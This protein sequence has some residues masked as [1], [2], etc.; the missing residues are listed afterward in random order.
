VH[1]NKFLFNKT[2]R[3]TN[4]PNFFFSRNCI[5]FGQ[6]LCPSSVVLH[7]TFGTGVCHASLMRASKHDQDGTAVQ[8]WSCLEAVIKLAWHK[9]VSNVQWKT[10]DDGQR[11]CP[12]QV[13]FLEKKIGK[14]VHLL[15]LLKRKM[16]FNIP[17]TQRQRRISHACD[18]I[19]PWRCLLFRIFKQ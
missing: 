10:P 15:L 9:P 16:N 4:F 19:H 8:S 2:N 6:F 18:G 14:L 1:C 3:R 12:K 7:C 5:C 11:N 17:V 13:Q